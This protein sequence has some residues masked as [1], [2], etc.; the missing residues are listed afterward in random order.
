MNMNECMIEL[1]AFE[2]LQRA[3][4]FFRFNIFEKNDS[5]YEIENS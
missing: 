3:I 5:S 4:T 1:D 2:G